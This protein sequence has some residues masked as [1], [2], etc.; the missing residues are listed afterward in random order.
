MDLVV[1]S[2]GGSFFIVLFI[3]KWVFKVYLSRYLSYIKVRYKVYF[4]EIG[5]FFFKVVFKFKIKFKYILFFEK[6]G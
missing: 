1:F 3:F 4:F 5:F 2:V 6:E